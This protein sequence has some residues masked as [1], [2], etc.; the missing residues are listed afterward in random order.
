MF[1]SSEYKFSLVS[2]EG[3]LRL[4]CLSQGRL[5]LSVL[6]KEES[7]SGFVFVALFLHVRVPEMYIDSVAVT[8]CG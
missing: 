2:M 4:L 7:D 6:S 5:C 8:L 3:L 1:F